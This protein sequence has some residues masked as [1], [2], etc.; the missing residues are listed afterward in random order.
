MKIKKNISLHDKNWFKTGG[1]ATWYAAPTSEIEFAKAIQHSQKYNLDIFILGQGANILI[2]DSGFNGLVIRPNITTIS[3]KT[4]DANYAQV[5]A[6]TGLSI[7]TVIEYCLENNL[8]GLEEFS[9]IPGTVGGS[10]YINIHYFKH[11]L[12]N[13]LIEATIIDRHTAEIKTVDKNWFD[14]GYDKS[15]LMLKKHFLIDASFLLKKTNSNQ[16]AYA[17]GRRAE[18]IR[19]R[20]A[21]YPTSNTCGS[22]F[23]NFFDNEVNLQIGGTNKKMI[24]VGYYL[25]K[26][27]VKGNLKVGGAIVSHKHA[28]MIVSNHETTSQDIIDLARSMQEMVQNKFRIIPQPE[29]QLVGFKE[30]PLLGKN[31]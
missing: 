11:F 8:V 25:D 9:G 16:T 26:L 6:G 12:S 24:Y 5:D 22:F 30:Y 10:V 7:D 21:R 13:F 29:C 15:K 23:R 3:H 17:K 1:P 2:S 31:E 18:I 27:G 14:F 4:I 20:N 19:H 28:N